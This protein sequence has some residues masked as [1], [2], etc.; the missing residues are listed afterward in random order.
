MGIRTGAFDPSKS[1]ATRPSFAAYEIQLLDDAGT[2]ANK[3]CTG[4]LYRYAAPKSNRAFPAPAWNDL[5]ITCTGQIIRV[6]LNGEEVLNAD[7]TKID[8]LPEKGRPKDIP[9]PKD[10]P[11]RGYVAL[12]SH[13]GTVYFR[14]VR[15]KATAN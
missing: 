3:G 6:K 2:P 12:Q 8:D 4:S 10:K 14:N 7:Q 11:V 1:S 9:A 5:E 15:I 13:T